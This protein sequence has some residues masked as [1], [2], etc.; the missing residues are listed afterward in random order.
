MFAVKALPSLPFLD[1]HEFAIC[2]R[3]SSPHAQRLS[4]KTET[5]TTRAAQGKTKYLICRSD[6]SNA[7]RER[8]RSV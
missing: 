3:G 6:V 8:G 1:S 5:Y 7:G 2:H 4:R